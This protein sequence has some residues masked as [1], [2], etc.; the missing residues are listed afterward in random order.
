MSSQM[1]RNSRS[2][3]FSRFRKR[4]E[5][6]CGVIP[7]LEAMSDWFTVR[8]ILANLGRL[9]VIVPSHLF[10]ECVAR[11]QLRNNSHLRQLFSRLYETCDLWEIDF[12]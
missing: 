12:G 9:N 5:T 11:F 3:I 7:S 2:R 4:F 6:A 1:A 8:H 10:C